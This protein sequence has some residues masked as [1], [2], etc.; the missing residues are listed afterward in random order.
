MLAYMGNNRKAFCLGRQLYPNSAWDTN[1][2]KTLGATDE[3]NVFQVF[4]ISQHARFSLGINDWGYPIP[5]SL[6][7][8]G[9][10]I[11]G[12]VAS[13]ARVKDSTV[14]FLPPVPDRGQCTGRSDRYQL[15]ANLDPTDNST[16]H[17][18]R[19][20][21][22]ITIA[23]TSFGPDGHVETQDAT[24]SINSQI[25]WIWRSRWNNDNQP[26]N[27]ATWSPLTALTGVNNLDP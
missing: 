10:D 11:N 20:L 21:I 16:A 18:Q 14:I 15:N 3:N 12:P 19:P 6:L 24:T 2:N 4:G 13:T 9:G 8:V 23:P 7:G 1:A 26:H 27:E 22:A 5:G 17:S 25:G